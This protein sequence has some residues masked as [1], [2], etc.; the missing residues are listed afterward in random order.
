MILSL[1]VYQ[2]VDKTQRMFNDLEGEL[3]T[4]VG[5]ALKETHLLFFSVQQK[6][7]D[8]RPPLGTQFE[9]EN[10]SCSLSKVQFSHIE[11]NKHSQWKPEG[12]R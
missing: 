12:H 10:S 9:L 1:D 7:N 4:E 5:T 3:E 2:A 11:L 8:D 6:G